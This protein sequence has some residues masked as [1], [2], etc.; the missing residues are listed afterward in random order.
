MLKPNINNSSTQKQM[1]INKHV[2]FCYVVECLSLKSAKQLC[3]YACFTEQHRYDDG[4]CD[5]DE[6]D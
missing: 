5:D 4:N 3:N 2:K 1:N 6:L